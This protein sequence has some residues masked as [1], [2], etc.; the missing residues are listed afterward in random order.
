M[1]GELG[2]KREFPSRPEGMRSWEEMERWPWIRG[3]PSTPS[4]STRR[5]EQVRKWVRDRLEAG[6]YQSSS[7]WVSFLWE[8]GEIVC[9][10]KRARK[11]VWKGYLFTCIFLRYNYLQC[12]VHVCCTA[13]GF[14]YTYTHSFSHSLPLWFITGDW[15]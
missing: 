7:P 14:S 15:I 6:C 10:E 3:G 1:K 13:K 2:I 4:G 12:S 11:K 9:Y 5:T 8:A